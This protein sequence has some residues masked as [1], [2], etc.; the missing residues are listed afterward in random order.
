MI[1]QRKAF[2]LVGE[3]ARE[4][5]ILILVFIPLDLLVRPAPAARSSLPFS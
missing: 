1:N 3:T 2:S 5:G 4:V